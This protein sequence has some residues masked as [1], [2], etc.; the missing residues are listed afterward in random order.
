MTKHVEILES[1]KYGVAILTLNRPANL[2]AINMAMFHEIWQLLTDWADD[3]SVNCVVVR[4][5]GSKSFCAGG[6]VLAVVENRG[7]KAF[8]HE[9]YRCEYVVDQLIHRYPKP[10]IPLMDG[11]VMGGGAGISVHAQE[12]RVVTER[13]IFAMP[14]TALGLF[15]DVGASHF[16]S[17]APNAIGMYMGLTGT[18]LN[19]ADTIF[20]GIAD[21]CVPSNSLENLIDA[22][23]S[24]EDPDRAIKRFEVD[25]GPANLKVEAPAIERCFGVESLHDVIAQLEEED[26]DWSRNT[27]DLIRSMCPFSQALTFKNIQYATGRSLEECLITDFRL[28]LRLMDRDDYFEGARA[29]L[30]DKDRRPYWNPKTIEAV[31]LKQIDDC[32][33]PLDNED[34]AFDWLHGSRQ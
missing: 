21:H 27:I 33:A 24:G 29:I 15:P 31:D 19:A 4:G 5:A 32:F 23:H 17:R 10:F 13:T 3:P 11:I 26:S 20:S 6:D 28:A 14:E 7:D 2:N 18:R 30:I 8:M 22:L 9:V 34:L 25:P 1:V 16:L 12:R